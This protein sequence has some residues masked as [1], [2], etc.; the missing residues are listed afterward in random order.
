MTREAVKRGR[1]WIGTSGWSYP[2]WGGRFYPDDIRKKDWFAYFAQH[3]N[4]VELNATFY[5]LFPETTYAGW[6]RKAPGDFV[7]AVKMW[8]WVTHRKKLRGVEADTQTAL[9]RAALLGRRLGP[10]LVQL[11]PGLKRDDELLKEYMGVLKET[12]RRIGRR[13]AL[14]FEFRHPSWADEEVYRMLRRDRFALCLPDGGRVTFPRTVTA[15]FTYV[16]FHG[17]AGMA[18]SLY[19][20]AVL[21]DWANWLRAQRNAGIDVYVYFNNDYNA[22][23]ITNAGQMIGLMRNRD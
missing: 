21:A 9:E 13:F 14:T 6:E 22:S 15:P 18:D 10:V 23:A 11:P 2:H 1:V 8:Q 4:T 3:F 12:P 20:E 17:R 19:P 16:R 5:H 7:Y